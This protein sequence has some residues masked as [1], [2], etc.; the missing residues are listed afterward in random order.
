LRAAAFV[1]AFCDVKTIYLRN[2]PDDVAD[3]LERMATRAGMS[4]SAFT[5]RELGE[6]ARRA[7]N[8]TLMQALPSMDVDVP[9]IIEALDNSRSTR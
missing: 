6:V 8:E 2:V 4:L 7:D 9:T 5:V 1:L 3:K